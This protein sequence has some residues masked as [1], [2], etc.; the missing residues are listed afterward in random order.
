MCAGNTMILIPELALE[1]LEYC[2]LPEVAALST[3]GRYTARLTEKHIRSRVRN[4]LQVL[5]PDKGKY[6]RIERRQ[7]ACLPERRRNLTQRNLARGTR[8][9]RRGRIVCAGIVE[10]RLYEDMDRP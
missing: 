4:L 9:W 2:D 7:T 6:V 1:V 3:M 8:R 10:G 5:F